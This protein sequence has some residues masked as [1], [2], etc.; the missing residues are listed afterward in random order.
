MILYEDL[1]WDITRRKRDP[2]AY[3]SPARETTLV[4]VDM[5]VFFPA[6]RREDTVESAVRLLKIA[7]ERRWAVVFLEHQGWG[8]TLPELMAV[9]DE[10]G[11]SAHELCSIQIK[12][13]WDGSA[14][15]EASVEAWDSPRGQFL[16]CGV[17]THECVQDTVIGLGKRFSSSRI[18]VVKEAC[19]CETGLP[20]SQFKSADLLELQHLQEPALV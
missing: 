5:Q 16:V 3:Q 9:V 4:V 12:R 15:V 2:L 17:N 19:N 8:H 18:G 13:T 20:W 14:E 6:T 10:A 1:R 11:G 7:L